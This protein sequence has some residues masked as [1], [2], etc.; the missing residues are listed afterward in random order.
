MGNFDLLTFDPARAIA[1]RFTTDPAGEYYGVWSADGKTVIF[2]STRRGNYDLFRKSVG[3]AG[4]EELVFADSTDKVPT[5]LSRDGR[6]LLYFTGGGQRYRLW[7][8]LLTPEQAGAPLH[9]EPLLNTPGNERWARFSPSTIRWIIFEADDSG[10]EEIYAAPF[11]APTERQ[12]HF[13]E[14]GACRAGGRTDGP[15]SISIPPGI[16]RKR[17]CAWSVTP[18]RSPRCVPCSR[19]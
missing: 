8:L 3:G 5:S 2:N 17:R 12:A 19:A 9:A 13:P 1:S 4:T 15:S 6:Y 11:A 7:R 14:R 18:W 16:C 10:R